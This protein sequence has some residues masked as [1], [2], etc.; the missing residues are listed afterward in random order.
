MVSDAIKSHRAPDTALAFCLFVFLF[1]CYMLAYSGQL[2]TIDETSM[3]AVTES[4]VKWGRLDTNQIAWSQ[5]A[6]SPSTTQGSFGLG[7]NVFSKKGLAI[8][9][10]AVPLYWIGMN[11]SQVGLVQITMLLN[12]IITALTGV[13]VFLYLRHLGYSSR[14]SLWVAFLFGLGTVAA[15]YTK[16][17]SS[18]PVSAMALLLAVYFALRCHKEQ[19]LISSSLAGLSLGLAVATTA[20]NLITAPFLLLYLSRLTPHASHITNSKANNLQQHWRERGQPIALFLASLAVVC[21]LVGFYNDARFGNPLDSGRRFAKG[22]TFSAPLWLGLYGLLFSPYKSIFLYSPILLAC[23]VSFPLFLKRHRLEG[24]LLALTVIAH[25]LLFATWYMWWGGFAWGPRFL[26]P[27]TPLL[28][29]TLAPLVEGVLTRGSLPAKLALAALAL[30]ST[31]IQVLGVSVNFV[32]YEVKLREI[33][34]APEIN[35][36]LYDPPAL[37]DLRYSPILGQMRLLSR[38]YS[39]LAWLGPDWIDL[40]VLVFTLGLILLSAVL[41]LQLM[42]QNNR[43]L[44]RSDDF[45]RPDIRAT[46][47]ATTSPTRGLL[48]LAVI[49][50]VSMMALTGFSLRRYYHDP[51]QGG[52]NAGYMQ[53]LEHIEAHTQSG[54]GIVT[55]TPYQYDFPMNYYRGRLPILGLAQAEPPLEEGMITLL[56]GALSAHRRLWLVTAGIQPADPT[57]GIE[58]WL[59]QR[60]FKASDEWYGDFRLCLY[61]SPGEPSEPI[62]LDIQLGSDISLRSYQISS[63]SVSPGQIVNLSLYWQALAPP[64]RNYKV[65][66][67]LLSPEGQLVSQRDSQPLDGFRPTSTWRQGQEIT[68]RYGLLLPDMLPPGAYQLVVGMYDGETG[69]RLKVSRWSAPAGADAVLLAEIQV[70]VR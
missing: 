7:G 30:L 41:I 66:V 25:L 35:P 20:A 43:A 33:F 4:M 17:L 68:D 6:L 47:V 57:N 36:S 55:I 24:W 49:G 10:L 8:S 39:D 31:A 62:P 45:S 38:K 53:A 64:D 14:V 5:W 2:H 59:A 42:R 22:E 18:E 16:V 23:L 56:E 50:L 46:K 1:A 12:P 15:V 29:L 44:I 19:S 34:P 48:T 58:E 54:D 13:I 26:V 67:Q 9:L 61:G 11:L 65:F 37:Y 51:L 63:Q 27:L 60:A 40:S 52:P 21:L 32:L 70:G 3:F 69:Q 28:A